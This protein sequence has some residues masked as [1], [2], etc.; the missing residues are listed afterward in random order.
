MGSSEK[1]IQGVVKY[2]H[3]R[4]SRGT[5]KL[6]YDFIKIQKFSISYHEQGHIILI[7]HFKNSLSVGSNMSKSKN[8]IIYIYYIYL[9]ISND[10]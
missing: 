9:Y 7:S 8:K 4:M 5:M 2:L 1:K 10:E 6:S 3:Y